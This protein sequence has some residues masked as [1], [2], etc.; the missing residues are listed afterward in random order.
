MTLCTN[1]GREI[2]CGCPNPS[3]AEVKLSTLFG[4]VCERCDAYND[5]GQS[6]C[7][8]CGVALTAEAPPIA[9][10]VVL[11]AARPLTH[12]PAPVIAAA[13]TTP[14][15]API[16]APPPQPLQLVSPAPAPL[17]LTE[18]VKKAAIA[19][20]RCGH[21]NP[22]EFRF[23]TECGMVLK[24][25]EAPRRRAIAQPVAV[26]KA[27][28]RVL[29]GDRLGQT[30][31]IGSRAAA[32]R[33]P[34]TLSFPNDPFLS[35]IHCVFYFKNGHFMVKDEGSGSGTFVRLSEEEP[36]SPSD[37]FAIGDHLLRF[38]GLLQPESHA[39][40]GT[41]IFG[42]PRPPGLALK[43]EEIYEGMLPGRTSVRLGPTV[44]LGRDDGSDLSFSGDPFVSGS[45][46]SV[47]LGPAGRTTLRDLGST[48]GTFRRLSPGSERE[49]VRGDCVRI[50]SEVLQV[51]EAPGPQLSR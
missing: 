22:P 6:L 5:S 26:G 44:T 18:V 36:L 14:R 21:Q 47:T 8:A 3:R 33:S 2:P 19:C 10:E 51:V 48:N 37:C 41:R 17:A 28:A 43:I 38:L 24:P 30:L 1:C 46:C 29:R 9:A 7:V 31:A 23:C 25:Q 12:V 49:L 34:G 27:A 16:Q 13:D 45:H 20:P 50:G 42:C 11:P 39:P 32:G 40:D 4:L 15:P 35:P